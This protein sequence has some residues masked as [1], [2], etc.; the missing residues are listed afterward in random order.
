MSF[1]ER[2]K[3]FDAY[4]KPLED[5]RV[6]T[7]AGGTVTL[8]SGAVI[9]FMFISETYFFL[10]VDIVEQLYVDS[11]PAE[12][13][14]D[15]HFDVTFPRLPCSVI[16]VDVMDLSGDNQDDIK[17]DVY[18]VSL[19]DGKVDGQQHVRQGSFSIQCCNS[20]D[21]VREAYTLRG[22]QLADIENVEQCKG[23]SWVQKMSDHK[24]EGCRVYGKVQ[25]AKVAG[26]FHIAPGDPLKSI[27]SH[28]HDLHSLSPTKFDTS[29]TINHLSFG[30]PYPRKVYPLDGRSFG[31]E[32][33]SDGMMYQYYL[34]LV[35][36]SYVY[37]DSS[38]NVFSHQFSVTTYHKD[39]GLGASGLPGF[40]VQYEFSPLMIK[41]EERR[42]SLST[43][44]VS[45]CAII[46]G[47]FTVASLIDAFIYRSARIIRQKIALNKFT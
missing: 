34:K 44:L 1:L 37:L 31:S 3:E 32:R 5:F 29:H 40:F 13:R 2:I 28:F 39:I 14:V 33:K 6:R 30:K 9:L 4:T 23:D 12:Q 46:G 10:S 35:P 17:D 47:I 19:I 8:I 20:C 22:W 38:R 41:Y 45:L 24:N 18:K 27:R 26:N 25:V 11:T 21:D 43:F 16:T 15:V 42:Q 36:T 7:F